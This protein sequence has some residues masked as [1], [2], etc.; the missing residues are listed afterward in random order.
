[1]VLERTKWAGFHLNIRPPFLIS[2]SA[3]ESSMDLYHRQ[4]PSA[5]RS[6]KRKLEQDFTDGGEE[7][8]AKADR[9]VLVLES[10]EP[11]QDLLGEVVSQV[12]ILKSTLSSSQSDRLAAKRAVNL[13]CD[14]AKNGACSS[15]SPYILVQFIFT[16]LLA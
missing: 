11:P 3:L 15:L 4:N 6:L 7:D 9:K 10:Q 8:P 1:M 12:T 16:L 5:R 13:L 14:L 2:L